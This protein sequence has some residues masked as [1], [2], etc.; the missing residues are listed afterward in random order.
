LRNLNYWKLLVRLVND[1]KKTTANS[2][3]K[4]GIN[5]NSRFF[6]IFKGKE[7][8]KIYSIK[9]KEQTLPFLLLEILS[10]N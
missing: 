1:E 7:K 5:I 8:H 4:H 2:L 9:K 10:Y 6:A 3:S